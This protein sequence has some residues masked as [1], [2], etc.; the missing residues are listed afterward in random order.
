MS[1]V[2]EAQ[3]ARAAELQQPLPETQKHTTS[4][5]SC[6]IEPNRGKEP[7]KLTE[8]LHRYLLQESQLLETIWFDPSEPDSGTQQD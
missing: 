4:A 8:V 7:S 3:P 2:T 5:W 1:S 6:G